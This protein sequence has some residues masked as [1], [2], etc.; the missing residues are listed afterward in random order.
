FLFVNPPVGCVARH[1]GLSGR[2]NGGGA[3][4][5]PA[6]STAAGGATVAGRRHRDDTCP[7]TGHITHRLRSKHATQ[8]PT[9]NSA[10]PPL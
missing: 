6:A 1:R 2:R 7:I 5:R 3:L 8:N 4:Q 10:A 9:E